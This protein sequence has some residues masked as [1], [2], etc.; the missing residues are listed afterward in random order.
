MGKTDTYICCWLKNTG[1]KRRYF[2]EYGNLREIKG[3]F[4]EPLL[5]ESTKI[6]FNVMKEC[7]KDKT[8]DGKTY[9]EAFHEKHKKIIDDRH[10]ST[11]EEINE[12]KEMVN[13][14]HDNSI[15]EL[16]EIIGK[17]PQMGE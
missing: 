12:Q 15:L 6:W 17:D 14:S 2:N 4:S 7:C 5:N 11:I 10:F 3:G 1:N 9:E 16:N 8:I 13:S